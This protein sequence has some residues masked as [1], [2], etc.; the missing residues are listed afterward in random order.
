MCSYFNIEDGREKQDFQ[1]SILYYFESG[2][3]AMTEGKKKKWQKKKKK[4]CEMYGKDDVTDQ[5]CQKRFTKFHAGDFSVY[6]ASR[7][8]RPGELDS[9]KIKMFIENNQHYTKKERV[10]KLKISKSS[11]ESH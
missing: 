7:T 9:N 2:K 5:T 8:R 11:I 6:K 4:I 10:N 3:N 1:N